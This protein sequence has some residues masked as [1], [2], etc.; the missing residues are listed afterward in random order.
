[1]SKDLQEGD[2]LILSEQYSVANHYLNLINNKIMNSIE[3]NVPKI[4]ISNLNSHFP[5]LFLE[6]FV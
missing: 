4:K 3:K 6:N 1:M 5:W 2:W